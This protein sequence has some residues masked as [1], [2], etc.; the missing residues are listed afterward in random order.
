[1]RTLHVLCAAFGLIGYAVA[2]TVPVD[3]TE[4]ARTS[5]TPAQGSPDRAAVL[6]QTA[7]GF[8]WLGTGRGLYRFDGVRYERVAAVGGVPLLGQFITALLAPQS[9]GLWIG[10]QYGG[11][12]FLDGR[13]IKNYPP[14]DG[15]LS[16]GTLEAFAV[17]PDGVVWAG[18]T[19]GLARLEGQRWSDVSQ[20]VG[21]PAPHATNLMV[22]NSGNL[23]IESADKLALL[24]R[25]SGRVH[26]YDLPAYQGLVRDPDGRVWNM[27]S[28]PNCLYLL[29]ATHNDAPPCRR[30]PQAY[31]DFWLIDRSG[32]VWVSDAANRLSMIP[33]PSTDSARAPTAGE[34]KSK[35][36]PQYVSFH[37]GAAPVSVLQDREGNVW[38]GTTGGLQQLRVPRFRRHG[39]FEEF[40]VLGTGNHNSLWVATTHYRSVHE[41]DFFQLKDGRM[42]PYRGGPTQIT[43]SYRD[44]KGVLWMGGYGRLW[45]LNDST[46]E[47]IAA[48]SGGLVNIGDDAL[49]RTQAIAR[50]AGGDLWLSVVR[51]GLFRERNQHWERVLVP[52]IPASDYPFVIYADHDGSVWLGYGQG[53]LASLMSGTWRVFTEKDGINVGSI[54]VLSRINDQLWIGGERGLQRFHAGRFESIR[55]IEGDV[56]GLLQAKNGDLWLNTSIGGVHVTSQ[57]LALADA[58]PAAKLAYE[59]FDTLDGMP[60]DATGIRPMPTVLEGD[61][62]RIWFE[63]DDRFSSI[64]PTEHLKNTIA[65]DVIIGDVTDDS[66]RREPAD[67]LT[68]FPS[69]HNVAIDYT[70]T[71]LSIP[72]R[73]RFKYRLE[74]FDESWQDVGARRTAYYNNLPPGRYVFHVIAANDDGVWN[75]QGAAIVLTV[76][77]LFYQTLWFRVVVLTFAFLLVAALFLV[78][79]RQVTTGERRRLEQR[80]EVR[81]NERTRIAREL[82][83]SL[84]QGFQGLMFRL[85]AVRQLL[86]GRP[87]DAAESLESALH[88]GDQAIVEGRDAV[89]N[90]RATAF[91]E[92]D[93]TA[94]LRTLGEELGVEIERE[95]AP[96]YGLVVEGRPRQ[97]TPAV[98]DEAYRIVREAARN[99]YRHAHAQQIEI[100]VTYGD[101][102]FGIRVRDDG[103]GIHPQILARGRRSGHWGLPGMRERSESLGGKLDVWS[104]SN[105]GTEVEF[106]IPAE[107]AYAAP[108]GSSFAR[109][110]N[111]LRSWR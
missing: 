86:P 31:T 27:V 23:W 80:M 74:N 98:R 8:L 102:I 73:V 77:P 69:V 57:D 1:M 24:R 105:A 5:F 45:K 25:G 42:V 110:K 22:D 7:D 10:Y 11:A 106:R 39:P 76:P 109:L 36:E 66:R 67:S 53:R 58:T 89:E 55:G 61:D 59:V 107:I 52:G 64:D 60:G 62:G 71:S 15:G 79:L 4:Y 70:A 12:S 46:W 92:R 78:R 21:L 37:D 97:L 87:A 9:G 33:T 47:E 40:V 96:R 85:Q 20:T 54:Q 41:D 65:P 38:F 91:D 35:F 43:A 111:L 99:A 75:S 93:L 95:P 72:S 68:L 90:L 44:A 83:D 49:R 88:L 104:E 81:L 19:R 103:I 34:D 100:E 17:D 14:Q 82:H 16:H 48:P 94:S 6:A 101:A 32:N 2:S 13:G 29:D 51:V 18:S 63:A 108:H 30:I 28:N 3:I 84:L 26:V 50:D 56:T